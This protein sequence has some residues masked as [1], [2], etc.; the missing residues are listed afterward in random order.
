MIGPC[1]KTGLPC[2]D[3]LLAA[4]LRFVS[5]SLFLIS[6]CRSICC[7][8]ASVFSAFSFSFCSFLFRLISSSNLNLLKLGSKPPP[9]PA[10]SPTADSGWIWEDAG[11]CRS[12]MMSNTRSSSAA[13]ASSAASSAVVRFRDLGGGSGNELRGFRRVLIIFWQCSA[14]L[15]GVS[16]RAGEVANR[17]VASNCAAV[18]SV[19]TVVNFPR[20]RFAVGVGG[21]GIVAEVGVATADGGCCREKLFNRTGTGVDARIAMSPCRVIGEG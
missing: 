7:R 18:F 13:C 11:K 20:A 1:A 12:S 19:I 8:S 10:P 14:S 16:N 6:F 21:T 15:A 17:T 5:S 9:T 3:A 2:C 4:I